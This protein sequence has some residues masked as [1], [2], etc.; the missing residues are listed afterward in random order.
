MCYCRRAAQSPIWAHREDLVCF[1]CC[2]Y[3]DL[4]VFTWVWRLPSSTLGKISQGWTWRQNFWND[5]KWDLEKCLKLQLPRGHS[6]NPGASMKWL[7]RALRRPWVYLYRY[8]FLFPWNVLCFA[9]E[10]S[11][12]PLLRH[13]RFWL[14]TGIGVGTK[15]VLCFHPQREKQGFF[16]SH[17]EGVG[18]MLTPSANSS[19]PIEMAHRWATWN[20]S[21]LHPPCRALSKDW[22]GLSW[23]LALGCS[24]EA[25]LWWM[26]RQTTSGGWSGEVCPVSTIL[27]SELEREQSPGNGRV[28]WR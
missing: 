11:F 1:Q 4:P 5:D 17:V 10:F 22:V 7:H 28:V 14:W 24:Q 6:T 2:R 16:L 18:A 21:P 23:G 12:P 13:S 8:F 19:G 15:A 26:V 20:P 9:L 25:L 3:R 27:G